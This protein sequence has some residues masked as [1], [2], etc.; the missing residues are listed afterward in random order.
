[1]EGIS[2]LPRG[3][4]VA[5]QEVPEVHTHARNHRG[6]A[7]GAAGKLGSA[8]GVRMGA[9]GTVWHRMVRIRPIL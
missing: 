1:M 2:G 4:P 8:Y 5:N 9:H 3:G 7:H 6:D